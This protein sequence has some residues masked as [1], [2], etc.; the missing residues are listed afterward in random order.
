MS[1][2]EGDVKE[3][4]E[5]EMAKP[6]PGAGPTCCLDLKTPHFIFECGLCGPA[7]TEHG[8]KRIEFMKCFRNIR[9]YPLM[10]IYYTRL[11]RMASPALTSK[12]VCSV[13]G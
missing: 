8:V 12:F 3:Q 1:K 13:Q 10:T 2:G 5:M 7:M 9:I 4:Q 11:S 6:A